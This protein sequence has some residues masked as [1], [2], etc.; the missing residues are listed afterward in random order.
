MRPYS[1]AAKADVRRR[2]GPP[3]LQ[4]VAQIS[5]ELG[6]HVITPYKWRKASRLQGRW[7]LPARW[8]PRVGARPS[9]S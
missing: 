3:H 6:P 9:S 1:E 5:R 2:M 4:K 8:T 7:C